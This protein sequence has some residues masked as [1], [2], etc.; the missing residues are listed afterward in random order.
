MSNP[1]NCRH[2][3]LGLCASPDSTFIVLKNDCDIIKYCNSAFSGG[4]D[5]VHH[6]TKDLRTTPAC[7]SFESTFLYWLNTFDGGQC[8]SNI[9]LNIWQ[10]KKLYSNS[11]SPQYLHHVCFSVSSRVNCGAEP[12]SENTPGSWKL[13]S[14]H[15]HLS[16]NNLTCLAFSTNRV[17]LF[18]FCNKYIV[19][20]S[21]TCSC[22][23]TLISWLYLQC[24]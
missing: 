1:V 13:V 3:E 18:R 14:Y 12:R 2:Q 19:Q 20:C 11:C 5:S 7:L 6:T 17:K 16:S 24:L 10:C 21:H 8:C 15:L 4:G 22:A 9:F 23:F